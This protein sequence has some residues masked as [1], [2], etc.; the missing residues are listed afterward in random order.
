MGIVESVENWVQPQRD[1]HPLY[2]SIYKILQPCNWGTIK[3]V[4][5]NDMVMSRDIFLEARGLSE[6]RATCLDQA[7]PA[8]DKSHRF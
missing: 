4:F 3:L 6:G 5:G 7:H 8:K 1:P 2:I